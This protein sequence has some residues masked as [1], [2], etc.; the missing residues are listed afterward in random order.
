LAA[1]F[2]TLALEASFFSTLLITPTATVW[3]IS[4]TA[5]RPSGGYYEKISTTR[6]FVGIILIISASPFFRSTKKKSNMQNILI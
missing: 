2:V 5:K 1:D 3:R 6:G 4:L